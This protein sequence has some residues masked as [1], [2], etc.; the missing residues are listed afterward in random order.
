MPGIPLGR[1]FQS[2]GRVLEQD[3]SGRQRQAGP[4]IAESRENVQDEKEKGPCGA[5]MRLAWP[6]PPGYDFPNYSF[7]HM[8]IAGPVGAFPFRLS[9]LS[10]GA[11]AVSCTGALS[12]GCG[13][14]A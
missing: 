6:P 1:G 3:G 4:V 9:P 12:D 7:P 11:N 2:A 13:G 8:G 14:A 10:S 5:A